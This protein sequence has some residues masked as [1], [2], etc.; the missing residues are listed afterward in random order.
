MVKTFGF[1]SIV[2]C[3]C[4]LAGCTQYWYQEGKTFQECQLAQ[5]EC[6]QELQKRTDF[7]GTMDYEFEY[8]TQCM[9]EKGYR[10]VKGSEL[11]MDAKRERP[12]SALHWRTKGIAGHLDE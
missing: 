3:G 8:M 5:R 4:L 2:F 6:F 10:L 11:P 1:L 7:V 9:R 12:D